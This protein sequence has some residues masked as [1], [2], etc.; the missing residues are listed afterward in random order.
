[1][2]LLDTQIPPNV[3]FVQ[4]LEEYVMITR[5]YRNKNLGNIDYHKR[6]DWV[7]QLGIETGVVN[8]RFALFD[9]FEHGIRALSILLLN[10]RGKDGLP[11]VGATGIDTVFELI[12][13]WAPSNENDTLSY[14][15][16]VAAR[17][18]VDMYKSI[19][20]SQPKILKGVVMGIINHENGGIPVTEDVIESG[21][22]MALNR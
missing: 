5:G 9:S 3:L 8:P 16:A 11:N 15:K 22:K 13:R 10:Y 2:V 19:D 1:M 14:A 20:I 17:L 18:G 6:N 4:L 7:G 12:S 21:I